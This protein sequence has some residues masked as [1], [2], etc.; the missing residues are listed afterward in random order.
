MALA[1]AA[2]AQQ[3]D[4]TWARST[5]G[6]P[7]RHRCHGVICY[8]SADPTVERARHG[9]NRDPIHFMIIHRKGIGTKNEVQTLSAIRSTPTMPTPAPQSTASPIPWSPK[10]RP[11]GWPRPATRAASCG[12]QGRHQARGQGHQPAR[13][14]HHRHLFA[15]RRHRGDETPSTRPAPDRICR[16]PRWAIRPDL[17]LGSPLPR[18]RRG[19][20]DPV[21]PRPRPCLRSCCPAPALAQSVQ[22]LGEFRAWSSLCGARRH[23]R[24]L[25]CHDQAES[26][27]ADAR[28]LHPGLSLHHPPAG[29]ERRQRVQPRRRLRLR[30]PTAG[31]DQVGGQSFDLFTQNDAAWLLDAEPERQS[32]R[33]HPRRLDAG[34]RGHHRQ[35]HQGHPDL[36]A[37]RRHRRQPAIDG[38]C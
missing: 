8:I 15:H 22:L 6:P 5:P 16:C 29:R 24:G 27:D 21:R 35:R 11:P 19:R 17:A 37:V 26:V 25:L 3:A 23:G 12:V 31:D 28:W 38:G 4:R 7:G 18:Y 14:Q 20:H 1:P 13:H 10:A 30:S 32:G 33:R 2:Q 34:H 9:A 36:F